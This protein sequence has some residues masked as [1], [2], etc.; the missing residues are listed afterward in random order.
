MKKI[1]KIKK[2]L[3]KITIALFAISI[4]PSNASTRI[5]GTWCGDGPD[6][7]ASIEFLNHSF[8][9]EFASG[10]KYEGVYL[11]KNGEVNMVFYYPSGTEINLNI[12]ERNNSLDFYQSA[13]NNSSFTRC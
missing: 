11:I 1:S 8:T 12:N 6:E 2:N 4:I 7:G 9:F 10:E 13:T 3:L 5:T